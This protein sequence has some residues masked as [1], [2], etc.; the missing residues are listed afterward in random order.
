V[1]LRGERKFPV[2]EMC[3][4]GGG[5]ECLRLS[6]TSGAAYDLQRAFYAS[7]ITLGMTISVQGVS[8]GPFKEARYARGARFELH[9]AVGFRLA[10]CDENVVIPDDALPAEV[11]CPIADVFKHPPGTYINVQGI[12]AHVEPVKPPTERCSSLRNVTLVDQSQ[13]QVVITIWGL[14]AIQ[15]E[16]PPEDSPLS[17]HHLIAKPEYLKLNTS[18]YTQIDDDCPRLVGW[19]PSP[20]AVFTLLSRRAQGE[21]RPITSLLAAAKEK[22]SLN[23]AKYFRAVV[24]FDT[25][26]TDSSGSLALYY[27]ACSN[28]D[29]PRKKLDVTLTCGK[30]RR[31]YT[32]GNAMAV[33]NYRFR[34]SDA[35]YTGEFSGSFEDEVG[36]FLFGCIAQEMAD[37]E[38]TPDASDTSGRRAKLQLDMDQRRGTWVLLTFKRLPRVNGGTLYDSFQVTAAREPDLVERMNELRALLFPRAPLFPSPRPPLDPQPP[39]E[40]SSD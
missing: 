9:P 28:P 11:Y 20:G 16:L 32:P 12:I 15:I 27:Y 29:C 24:C 35:W 36:K 38:N 7:G 2:F 39:D 25:I 33:Y 1:Q 40:P 10:Q 13:A 22:A 31:V 37:I 18:D 26:L 3:I 34:A 21:D 30:C 4:S 14:Q 23:V 19:H 17:L 6:A 8:V 5:Q